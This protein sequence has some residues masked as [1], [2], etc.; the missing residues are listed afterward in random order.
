VRRGDRARRRDAISLAHKVPSA[1]YDNN[2][3]SGISEHLKQTLVIYAASPGG[4]DVI[5][6]FLR[7]DLKQRREVQSQLIDQLKVLQDTDIAILRQMGRLE[8]IRDEILSFRFKAKIAGNLWVRLLIACWPGGKD[9][10][11]LLPILKKRNDI[12]PDDIRRAIVNLSL[13]KARTR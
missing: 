2:E 7:A 6:K 12:D 3:T 13:Y 11:V 8:H 9:I 4:R 10:V 5:E 1:R